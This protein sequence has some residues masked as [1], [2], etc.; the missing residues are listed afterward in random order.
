M[1]NDPIMVN[2]NTGATLPYR[3]LVAKSGNLYHAIAKRTGD[4]FRHP[5]KFGVNVAPE[6]VGGNLPTS[7][8][9]LGVTVK[10][11]KGVS[12]MSKRPQVS[13]RGEVKVNGEPRIF[14]LKVIEHDGHFNVSG[15]INRAAGG[16]SKAVTAL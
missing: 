5:G 15:S 14:S 11:T 3:P 2:L 4:G 12:Q 8:T 7:A 6:V 1:A 9:V 13:F 16:G 10:G